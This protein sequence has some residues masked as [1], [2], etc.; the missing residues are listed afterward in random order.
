MCGLRRRHHS[1]PR[2]AGAAVENQHNGVRLIA[3]ADL[4]DEAVRARGQRQVERIRLDA[5]DDAPDVG[6]HRCRGSRVDLDGGARRRAN[7]VDSGDD[8]GDRRLADDQQPRRPAQIDSAVIDRGERARE[9]L[10]GDQQTT[11]CT[12]DWCGQGHDTAVDRRDRLIG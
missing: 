4:V 7:G 1:R 2:H 8:T 3:R 12:R 10:D 11:A 9:K 5:D 6:C